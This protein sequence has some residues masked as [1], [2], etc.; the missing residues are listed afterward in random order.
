MRRT[1]YKGHAYGG[2]GPANALDVNCDTT[3]TRFSSST[4]QGVVNE[5]NNILNKK[6]VSFY[7]IKNISVGTNPVSNNNALVITWNDGVNT[8]DN[9][10]YIDF[11]N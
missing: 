10:N 5:L 2:Y 1:Y 7:M 3:S 8:T 4:I 11:T 6:S 9:V